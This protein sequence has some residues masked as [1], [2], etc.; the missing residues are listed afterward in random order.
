MSKSWL[1]FGDVAILSQHTRGYSALKTLTAFRARFLDLI[2]AEIPKISRDELESMIAAELVSPFVVELPKA[3][4]EQAQTSVDAFFAL[5]DHPDSRKERAAEAARLGF[6]DPGNYSICMSYD[7]HLNDRRQLKLIEVNTNAAFLGLAWLMYQA[8][9]VPWPVAGFTPEELRENIENEIQLAGLAGHAGNWVVMDEKADQQKLRIEF[10]LFRAWFE[11]WGHTSFV[12]GIDEVTDQD[13]FIYNRY[14]DFFLKE[15]R[16]KHLRELFNTKRSCFSPQPMEYLSL[17]DKERLVE[18]SLNAKNE[19]SRVSP[20]QAAALKQA[21]LECY[22]LTPENA[23]SSWDRRRKLFFKPLRAFGGKQSYR[24]ASI[25][26]RYFDEL[27]GHEI[28]AQEYVPAPEVIVR[29]PEGEVNF[30]YDLRFYAY[31][32]RVQGVL[33]RLYQGQLTNL[34]TPYGGFTPVRFI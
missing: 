21:L 25:S 26:R 30:K 2:A 31:K 11:K 22:L 32:G 5:R 23:E 4:L 16:S 10:H 15:E 1:I 34:K 29:T 18:W 20:E 13:V 33:A 6:K 28:L 7:Y 14:T 24:G 27:P 19:M 12:R 3:V 8:A 9:E 17:A